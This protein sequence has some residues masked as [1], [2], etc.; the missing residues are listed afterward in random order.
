MENFRKAIE[1]KNDF[2][3]DDELLSIIKNMDDEDDKVEINLEDN[4]K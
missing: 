1:K 3:N 4:V 2:Q